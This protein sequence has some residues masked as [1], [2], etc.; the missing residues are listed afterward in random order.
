MWKSYS[1]VQ[2]NKPLLSQLNNKDHSHYCLL[3][4]KALTLTAHVGWGGAFSLGK[5]C[6]AYTAILSQT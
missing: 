3:K 4:S 5:A 1:H 6:K 2:E